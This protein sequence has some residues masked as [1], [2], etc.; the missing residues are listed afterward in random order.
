MIRLHIMLVLLSV[1]LHACSLA[2]QLP[3][4]HKINGTKY[5][6]HV[7][8]PGNTLYG[9][10]KL[11]NVEI[12][13]IDQNNPGV[14]K[15]GLKVNQTLLIPVTSDNKRSLGAVVEQNEDFLTHQAQPKETLYAISKR[16]DVSLELSL[17]HI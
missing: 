9:I 8:E 15:D 16:Y 13:A 5:Y 11:Y 1:L 4:V 2:Q 6:L 14:I 17:I 7:V 3:E 10:S 12:R